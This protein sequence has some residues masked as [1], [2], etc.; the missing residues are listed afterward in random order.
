VAVD[1]DILK[2]IE[3]P[4]I[5]VGEATGYVFLESE[6][7][8]KGQGRIMV[9][10]IDSSLKPV[11]KTITEDD[12]YYSYFGLTSG[13]YTVRIDTSQLRKLNMNSD[14]EAMQF[15]IDGG[16]DGDIADGL[17]F[18][19]KMVPGDTTAVIPVIP[20]MPAV[21]KDTTYMILHEL[22]EEVYTITKDS[23]AIQIGAFKSRSYAEGF[24]K[25]LKRELGKDVQITIEG[26]YYRVRILDLPTREEVDENIVKLN[27]LG[28]KELWIIHLLARQQQRMLITREDSLARIKETMIEREAPLSPAE[29]AELQLDA[30]R[31]RSN[32]IGLRKQ[33][34]APLDEKVTID[35]KG[36]Y[37][38]L[39]T[40]NQ[41]I[42]DPTVL[43]AIKNLIP[44]FGRLG[45]ADKWALPVKKEFVKTEPVEEP[46]EREPGIIQKVPVRPDASFRVTEDKSRV[47]ILEEKPEV[48]EPSIA[49]QVAIYVKESQA[50]RAQKR[51]MSKLNL[52]VEIVK[53]YDYYHVIVTGFYTREETYQYYPELAG[54]GYPGIT[55]IPNYIRQ[56]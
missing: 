18:I 17:N 39:E 7:E 3:I 28:F 5:I 6:G 50:L 47:L 29:R 8:K 54:L 13:I 52:P 44:S 1:P 51:I 49:L 2:N 22:S 37:Y 25:M 32:A 10:F 48:L 24:Q 14:P 4:V 31:L 35:N 41:P 33:L 34:S 40:P 38:R 16:L 21:K 19:L 9:S 55:L 53:Q 20:E 26:E 46:V 30:F 42:L 27:R 43:E 12:G 45:I 11:G 36:I 15:T 56:K 23:W